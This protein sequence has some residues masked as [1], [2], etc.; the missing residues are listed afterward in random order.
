[1]TVIYHEDQAD[2]DQILPRPVAVIGYGDIGRPSAIN[3]RDAAVTNIV[4]GDDSSEGQAN[5]KADGFRVMSV[6]EATRS[7]EIILVALAVETMTPVYMT[8]ISPNLAPQNVLIFI[9]GYNVAFGFIEAP[10]FVDVGL[11]AP[12]TITGAPR[13]RFSS[14]GGPF[15]SFVAVGQDS[16][17]NAWPVVLAVALALGAL[18]G[19]GVEVNLE[20]EAELS[21]FI[22]QAII[23]AFHNLMRTAAALLLKEGYPPEAIFQDLYIGGKFPDFMRNI[24]QTGIQQTLN[25]T[26]LSTQYATYSRFDRFNEIKLERLMEI[27]LD[28]IRNGDF[29]QEWNRENTDGHRRLDR[30]L[31]QHNDSELWDLEQQT[32][33]YLEEDFPPLDFNDDM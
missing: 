12:R 3:M 4:I 9:S 25:R 30:L 22:Q 14:D 17:G 32:L 5:A 10:P 11:V 27:T 28:E 7:A 16:T 1:M 24:A 29:A 19:G 31:K 6:A 33:D 23:P 21:L 15:S 26:T 20:Q 18:S 2:I 13:S 8:Q